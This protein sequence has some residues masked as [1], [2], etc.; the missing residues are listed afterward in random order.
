MSASEES[1]AL[2]SSIDA[3]LKLLVKQ[4]VAAAPKVIATDRQLD[5]QYGDPL[6]KFNPRDW[7]GDSFKGRHMSECPAAFLELLAETFDYFARTA[8]EKHETTNNGKPVGDYKR[9]DAAKARGWAKR[10]R[11]GLV[12]NSA[13]T[14]PSGDFGGTEDDSFGAGPDADTWN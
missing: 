2:L 12:K 8:D 6:V 1:L 7:T 13:Q 4:Q 9:L 14:E 11:E 3:S 5:G 10:V